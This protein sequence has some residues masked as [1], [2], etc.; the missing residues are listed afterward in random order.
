M[1]T[2]VTHCLTYNVILRTFLLPSNHRYCLC[3][4]FV[5]IIKKLNCLYEKRMTNMAFTK[6]ISSLID[7]LTKHLFCFYHTNL[8]S[9]VKQWFL[10]YC[11]V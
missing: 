11:Y 4:N 7:K 1:I 8:N 6:R 9:K 10:S 3:V 5:G 2:L